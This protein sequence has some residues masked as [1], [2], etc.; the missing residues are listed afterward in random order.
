MPAIQEHAAIAIRKFSSATAFRPNRRYMAQPLRFGRSPLRIRAPAIPRIHQI[1]L[2]LAP[3]GRLGQ[4]RIE[5]AVHMHLRTLALRKLAKQR[6]HMRGGHRQEQVSAFDLIAGDAM[7]EMTRRKLVTTL[8]QHLDRATVD[9]IA[10]FL[11]ADATGFDIDP[12]SNPRRSNS[13]RRMISAMGERQML[14][15]HTVIT[16]YMK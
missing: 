2:V 10:V 5:A 1:D 11:V 12:S 16:V 14:P 6:A 4:I 3:S 15:V 13:A 7:R 9:R 8:L